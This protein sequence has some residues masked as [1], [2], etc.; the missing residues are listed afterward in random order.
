[1]F[2][3]IFELEHGAMRAV[4]AAPLRRPLYERDPLLF[5]KIVSAL[6]TLA[7]VGCLALHFPHGRTIPNRANSIQRQGH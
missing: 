6:L 7:L 3:F 1:V 5:W 2:E 4:P